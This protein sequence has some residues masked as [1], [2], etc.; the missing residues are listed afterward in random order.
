MDSSEIVI[1]FFPI[2]PYYLIC[3]LIS[4]ISAFAVITLSIL[5]GQHKEPLGKMVII[6]LALDTI[7]CVPVIAAGH[8]YEKSGILC[9]VLIFIVHFGWEASCI[10]SA[11]FAYSLLNIIKNLTSTSI[12]NKMR[13]YMLAGLVFPLFHTVG[14][15][16]TDYVQYDSHMKQCVH[17][18]IPDKF[19]GSYFFVTSLPII[20]CCFLSLV[21]YGMAAKHLK[22]IFSESKNSDVI[23]LL[24][25]PSIMILCWGPNVILN[26]SIIF[27]QSPDPTLIQLFQGICKLQG[28]FNAV[29]YGCSKKMLKETRKLRYCR[30][31]GN[32]KDIELYRSFDNIET[33][34]NNSKVSLQKGYLTSSEERDASYQSF[35]Y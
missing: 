1:P 29:V 25:Y 19:D 11:L 12:E 3:P 34:E 33:E 18:A 14:A 9:E 10:W 7:F 17:V 5:T 31:L 6:I 24:L 32:E 2:S 8:P 28:F 16:F 13:W 20:M 4:V 30:C 23:I 15:I 35:G 21:W 27:G 26:S 22:R